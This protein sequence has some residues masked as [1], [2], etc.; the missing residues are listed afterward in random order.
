MRRVVAALAL[1]VVLVGPTRA[2]ATSCVQEVRAVAVHVSSCQR[3]VQTLICDPEGEAVARELLVIGEQGDAQ[4]KRCVTLALGLHQYPLAGTLAA[5]AERLADAAGSAW[6]AWYARAVAAH[7][8]PALLRSPQAA[9]TRSG[10]AEARPADVG[11]LM[12][13]D[14]AVRRRAL[15]ALARTGYAGEAAPIVARLA[16][17]DPFVRMA[18]AETIRRLGIDA[19]GA[20][21]KRLEVEEDPLVRARLVRA[22]AEVRG[23]PDAERFTGYLGES[24]SWVRS[25][26]MLALARTGDVRGCGPLAGQIDARRPDFR[27]G[28]NASRAV[29]AMG[30]L[31]CADHVPEIAALLDHSMGE[32]RL[33]AAVALGLIGTEEAR[34]ALTAVRPEDATNLPPA[35]R[36]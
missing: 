2:D 17:T 25:A 35:F 27:G 7:E 22:L 21:G 31:G 16:D 4:A 24:S 9:F 30:L 34:R 15:A 36:P 11:A 5:R 19:A 26:A 28:M 32:L 6:R 1:A 23:D 20:L 33:G 10:D 29:V 3:V 13:D 18:A 14:P 8:D 12:S